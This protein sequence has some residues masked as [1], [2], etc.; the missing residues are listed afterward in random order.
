MIKKRK[1]KGGKKRGREKWRK[2]EKE[3]RE[4]EGNNRF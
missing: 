2:I 3:D 1:R 4:K